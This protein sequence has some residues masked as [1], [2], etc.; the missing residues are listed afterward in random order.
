MMETRY[1]F[2][3]PNGDVLLGDADDQ[4]FT[5]TESTIPNLLM[6]VA[7]WTN[8]SGPEEVLKSMRTP[9]GKLFGST[10]VKEIV[11]TQKIDIEEVAAAI[12]DEY[13][14]DL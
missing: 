1:I 13:D 8:L 4:V 2:I 3:D 12:N 5:V 6:S 7:G 14:T 9:G 11:T 10:V